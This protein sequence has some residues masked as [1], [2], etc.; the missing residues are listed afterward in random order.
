MI[1][2][3]RDE[4]EILLVAVAEHHDRLLDKLIANPADIGL[5]REESLLGAAIGRLEDALT[6]AGILR[7]ES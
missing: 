4:V 1:R 6:P 2:F 3:D 7:G 5:A